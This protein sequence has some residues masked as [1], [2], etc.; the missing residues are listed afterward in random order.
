M[1]LATT[2][3]T[4]KNQLFFYKLTAGKLKFKNT[5]DN[6]KKTLNTNKQISWKMCKI[7]IPKI[8]NIT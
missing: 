3:S 5:I 6:I 8:Q 1:N 2:L 4:N 7:S